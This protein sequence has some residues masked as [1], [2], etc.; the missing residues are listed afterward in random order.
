MSNFELSR[1]RGTNLKTL[2][3]VLMAGTIAGCSSD[4]S[5]FSYNKAIYDGQLT[6][7]SVK[8]P[9]ADGLAPI[10]V[11]RKQSYP[12]DAR[13]PSTPQATYQAQNSVQQP[14]MQQYPGD[15]RSPL[16]IYTAS[17]PKSSTA[18]PKD[19]YQTPLPPKQ[20]SVVREVLPASTSPTFAQK[21]RNALA[22]KQ[23]KSLSNVVKTP[24]VANLPEV[25][26]PSVKPIANTGTNLAAGVAA[27]AVAGV[28]NAY[29]GAQDA[30][31]TG[32]VKSASSTNTLGGT[33]LVM[34]K[35]DPIVT[36]S[37]PN[38]DQVRKGGWSTIGG[39]KVSLSEGETVYNLSRRYG[40]PAVEILRANKVVDS[41]TLKAGQV[42]TIPVYAYS[43]LAP[44]S[45]PDNDV[46][47]KSANSHR[48]SKT[49]FPHGSDAP[50]PEILGKQGGGVKVAN[51]VVPALAP[52]K[53]PAN[54]HTMNGSS[55]ASGNGGVY[56]V[57]SGDTLN[58]VA[59]KHG[60]NVAELQAANGLT[61]SNIRI[62]QKL[63]IPGKSLDGMTFKNMAPD[64]MTT[65]SI[66]PSK[67]KIGQGV[68]AKN[69]DALTKTAK[70][71]A[72]IAAPKTTGIGKLRWPAK[73]QIV[74]SFGG[75][76]EAGKRNDGIDILMPEG[77]P[78]KAAENGVVIYSDSGL[79]G[80]GN[81]VLVRHDDNLVTVYAHARSLNVKR[82][83][84]VTRGQVVAHSGMSGSAKRPKLHFE[85]RHKAVPKNPI[86]Y[87]E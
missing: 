84:K 68:D 62:G 33:K 63:R 21:V 87:L 76:T 30:V 39:T 43:D 1:P 66:S 86:S 50:V 52:N 8:P 64:N 24:A 49:I 13:A 82:G 18:A 15:V 45:A 16:P 37:I 44:V 53:K 67:P 19:L 38:K 3:V 25:R 6:T 60:V 10:G 71:Q 41:R 2:I 7:A 12:G 80:F 23:K 5:R 4:L 56:T 27:G 54:Q 46:L 85:V 20:A 65:A 51:H 36:G 79:K 42:L 40:V 73:G 47:T 14:P 17:I 9:L 69:T 70:I 74:T 78:I 75:K 83:D 35:P 81:T 59:Y 48:G 72:D 22:G 57:S 11:Q 61:N 31:V 29:P 26:Q 28:K 58:R 32:S 77:S 55:H 34:M